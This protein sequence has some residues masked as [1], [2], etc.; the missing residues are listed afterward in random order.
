MSTD[1][2]TPGQRP[3]WCLDAEPED[4]SSARDGQTM[5]ST[6]SRYFGPRTAAWG[7]ALLAEDVTTADGIDA[8]PTVVRVYDPERELTL[9]EAEQF[10]LAIIDAVKTART[11]P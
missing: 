11:R 5:F 2:R 4:H 8:G 3:S 9:D 10:A 1:T 7:V 6:W